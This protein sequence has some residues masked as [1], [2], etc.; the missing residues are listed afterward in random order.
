MFNQPTT[1]L[2]ALESEHRRIESMLDIFEGWSAGLRKGMSVDPDAV[3][4]GL[5]F[6]RTFADRWHHGREEDL[7]FPAIELAEPGTKDSVLRVMRH[8]HDE[9][10]ALIALAATANQGVRDGEEKAATKLAGALNGFAMLL[11]QHI[12]KEDNVLFRMADQWLDDEEMSELATAFAAKEEALGVE[13]PDR[14]Q[15]VLMR[16][17]QVVAQ[18]L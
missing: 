8:E 18:P 4:E 14:Y 11:R 6:I 13:L 3:D 17:K 7:L 5:D 12:Y 15:M 9:G 16:L 1:P 10:R 2:S